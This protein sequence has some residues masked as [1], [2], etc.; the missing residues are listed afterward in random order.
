MGDSQ[1]LRFV[2]FVDD[3]GLSSVEVLSEFQSS[4]ELPLF[5]GSAYLSDRL[6]FGSLSLEYV[7][8]VDVV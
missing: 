4:S 1:S 8:P 7:P 3:W 5:F 2:G 6:T